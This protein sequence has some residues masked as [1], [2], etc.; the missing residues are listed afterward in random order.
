[1]ILLVFPPFGLGSHLTYVQGDFY[2]ASFTMRFVC[3]IPTAASGSMVTGPFDLL[4]ISSAAVNTLVVSGFREM[5]SFVLLVAL[6]FKMLSFL[7]SLQIPLNM[8]H[9]ETPV[10]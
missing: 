5:L 1:M 8:M 3:F 7:S 4:L 6:S 10:F 9:S 2:G